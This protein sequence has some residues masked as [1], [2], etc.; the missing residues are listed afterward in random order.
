MD[1]L[2]KSCPVDLRSAL[3]L[4]DAVYTRALGRRGSSVQIRSPRPNISYGIS[5]FCKQLLKLELSA[6][7]GPV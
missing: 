4:A 5:E 2:D 7:L 1:A 6:D 3:S